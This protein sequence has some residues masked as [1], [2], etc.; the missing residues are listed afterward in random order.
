[1]FGL[2]ELI[3]FEIM[4]RH[5]T[6]SSV[7][8]DRL[9]NRVD[10]KIITDLGRFN[11]FMDANVTIDE[12]YQWIDDRCFPKERPNCDRILKLLGLDFYV[13]MEI[14]RVTHGL[15]FDDYY[16]VKFKGEDINWDDIKLRD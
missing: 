9:N 1:M 4:H 15:Q 5:K 10:Y 16:W 13:P 3:E 6:M 8:I 12:V 11:P 14:V 7:K 2:E